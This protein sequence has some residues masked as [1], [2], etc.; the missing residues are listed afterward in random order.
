M[1]GR[2]KHPSLYLVIVVLT[3]FVQH[4]CNG[5]MF[6][7]SKGITNL[8]K[9]EDEI[10]GANECPSPKVAD[11]HGVSVRLHGVVVVEARSILSIFFG[12]IPSAVNFR[13]RGSATLLVYVLNL[14]T[15]VRFTTY[16][17]G[18]DNI[19]IL[20]FIVKFHNFVLKTDLF[21][22]L[23]LSRTNTVSNPLPAV[24]LRNLL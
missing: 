24:T 5:P 21:C 12:T 16:Y 7:Y 14:S 20:S 4:A 11:P 1:F 15:L 2:V 22:L 19:S 17:L 9:V 6:Y 10:W 8:H 13:K 3:L 23:S 18:C